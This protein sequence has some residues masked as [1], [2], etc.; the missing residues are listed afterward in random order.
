MLLLL[1]ICISSRFF[2]NQPNENPEKLQNHSNKGKGKEKKKEQGEAKEEKEK[3][4]MLS[5]LVFIT[6]SKI[7]LDT[8]VLGYLSM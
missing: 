8:Y 7:W 2:E 5:L 6:L 3:K 4:T 1:L